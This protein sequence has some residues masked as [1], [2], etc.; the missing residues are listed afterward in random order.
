MSS[1]RVAAILTLPT[2]RVAAT[3][4]GD[5]DVHAARSPPDPRANTKSVKPTGRVSG[6]SV[7]LRDGPLPPVENRIK[8]KLALAVGPPTLRTVT[9]TGSLAPCAWVSSLRP[10]EV[11]LK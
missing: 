7:M 3:R 9:R 11:S 4:H 8:F 2:V 6:E 10:R 5:T 1:G